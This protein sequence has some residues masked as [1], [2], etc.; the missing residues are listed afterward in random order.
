MPRSPNYGRLLNGR[1]IPGRTVGGA[2]R[3][4]YLNRKTYASYLDLANG[5]SSNHRQR[6]DEV[7]KQAILEVSATEVP[8]RRGA[9]SEAVRARALKILRASYRKEIA[10][11]NELDAVEED[12]AHSDDWQASPERMYLLNNGYIDEDGNIKE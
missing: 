10:K 2:L 5:S 8:L 9:F 7:M 1:T 11:K 4:V 12:F 3:S 6:V